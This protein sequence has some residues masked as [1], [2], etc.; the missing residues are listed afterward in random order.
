MK[1][2][3][4]ESHHAP[5]SGVEIKNDWSYPF[6]PTCFSVVHEEDLHRDKKC[7]WLKIVQL[8]GRIAMNCD[9][10]LIC[11]EIKNNFT[12]LAYLMNDKLTE[13]GR[14]YDMKMNV[15]KRKVMRIAR[16]PSTV[17]IM[18]DQKQL[19]NVK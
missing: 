8:V 11:S 4:C 1:R 18:M 12:S 2:L 19:E 10:I 17:T 3:S 16:Q 6:T 13:T 5:L 14:C 9:N 15:E 7:T